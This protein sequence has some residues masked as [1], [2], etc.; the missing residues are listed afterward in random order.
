MARS[1]LIVGG[2]TSGW[3]TAAYLSKALP[4]VEVT[5]IESANTG[6][7]GVGE[8]TF[9]T[10]R[11]FFDY[12]GLD[13][14]EWLPKCGGGY[15][16]GIRFQNWSGDGDHFYHPFERWNHVQGFSIAEWWLAGDRSQPF[17]RATFLTPHICEA[18]R[19]PHTLEGRTYMGGVAENL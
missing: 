7:I 15:K 9:S 17:D 2:G 13:E 1:V 19:A 5:L 18:R 6:R 4:T 10:I 3:M 16:L 11:H 8:A 14:R 12:L